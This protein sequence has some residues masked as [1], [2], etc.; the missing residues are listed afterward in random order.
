MGKE[1]ATRVAGLNEKSSFRPDDP[2]YLYRKN[3]APIE[4]PMTKLNWADS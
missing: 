2:L 1:D 4:G 3:F